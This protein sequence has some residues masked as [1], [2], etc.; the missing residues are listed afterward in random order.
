VWHPVR[1]SDASTQYLT[2]RPGQRR[3][4]VRIPSAT[5]RFYVVCPVVRWDLGTNRSR[6]IAPEAAHAP[7]DRVLGVAYSPLESV[8][9]VL[10]VVREVRQVDIS[11]GSDRGGHPSSRLPWWPRR[12]PHWGHSGHGVHH[13]PSWHFGGRDV[14]RLYRYDIEKGTSARLATW[15]YK[16]L[17][18]GA[19]LM[20][21]EGGELALVVGRRHHMEA[22]LFQDAGD[23]LERRGSLRRHGV[24]A[25]PPVMGNH[26]PVV[27]LLH[28]G[29]IE[30]VTLELSSFRGG[31]RCDEL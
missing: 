6:Y 15:L 4:A 20:L 7:S 22:F 1:P 17:S 5:V 31:E 25:A 27:A 16:G 21:L 8:L 18:T 13:R 30:Y 10:D 23:H 2:V 28:D 12:P 11:G 14:A 29:R 9:Y 3:I 19:H 26:D 24:L